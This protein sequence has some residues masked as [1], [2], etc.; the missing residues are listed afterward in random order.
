[1]ERA[2]GSMAGCVGLA[3]SVR[4]TDGEMM[5]ASH[6]LTASRPA[7][8]NEVAIRTR[9]GAPFDPLLREFLD[10]FYG[11]DPGTRASAI[12]GAPHEIGPIHDAYLAAVAEHLAL[13]YGLADPALGRATATLSGQ[14]VLRGRTGEP[15]GHPAGRESASV[16]AAPDIRKCQRTVAPARAFEWGSLNDLNPSRSAGSHPSPI[17]PSSR[18]RARDRRSRAG[19]A[20]RDRWWPISRRHN[21]R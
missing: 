5:N 1:M 11:G 21:S 12:A 19:A 8:L 15:Q 4:A 9:D 3:G 10:T 16:P 7:T 14:A 17:H 20:G 6:P 13:K 18:H 2:A